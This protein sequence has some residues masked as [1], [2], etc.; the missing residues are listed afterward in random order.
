MCNDKLNKQDQANLDA[1]LKKPLKDFPE[2]L[3]DYLWYYNDERNLKRDVG[4]D[5]TIQTS[6]MHNCGVVSWGWVKE[7][8]CV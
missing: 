2:K 7:E 3:Y 8:E 5:V 4:T 1:C 6:L